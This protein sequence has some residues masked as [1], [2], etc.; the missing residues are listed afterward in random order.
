[1]NISQKNLVLVA[2]KTNGHCFYCGSKNAFEIDHFLPN[3]F[4][5]LWKLSGFVD[6]NEAEN[7]FLACRECNREK[8]FQHPEVFLGGRFIAWSRYFRANF[9]VGLVETREYIL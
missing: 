5:R 2:Q 9:R 1:M 6:N 8:G 4:H 7:L 3:Y